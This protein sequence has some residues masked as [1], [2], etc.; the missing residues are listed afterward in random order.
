MTHEDN[1]Q[2][3]AIPAKTLRALTGSTLASILAHLGYNGIIALP[4]ILQ[5]LAR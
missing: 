5:L 4:F 2:A 3:V 1:S